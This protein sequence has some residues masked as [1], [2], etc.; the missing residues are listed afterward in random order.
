LGGTCQDSVPQAIVAALDGTDFEDA[1]RN[2]ISIGGDSDTIGCITGS[3]AETLYGIPQDIY[4]ECIGYLPAE[5]IAV[6]VEFEKKYGTKIIKIMEQK[7]ELVDYTPEHKRIYE[8]LCEVAAKNS[9]IPY[10]EL[11]KSANVSLDMSIPYDRGRLGNIL[12][13]IS[14]NETIL[15]HPMLSSVSVQSGTYKQSQGFFD[16]A[17]TIYG[18]TFHDEDEKLVFGMKEMEKTHRY[19]KKVYK[20]E[21]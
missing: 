9:V 20:K 14:W 3:I 10:A 16:I 4:N 1:I 7:R 8:I 13:D 18:R 15:G 5:L 17:E 11:V 21:I 2:A 19:W 6:V 12:G